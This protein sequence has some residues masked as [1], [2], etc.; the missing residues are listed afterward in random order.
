MARPEPFINRV[1]MWY[2]N[3]GFTDKVMFQLAYAACDSTAHD[4]GI[5]WG[6]MQAGLQKIAKK[7]G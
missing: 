1:V 7:H 6:N 2:A 5:H 3:D 4:A